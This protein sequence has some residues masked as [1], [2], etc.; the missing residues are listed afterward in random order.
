MAR[1]FASAVP[2]ICRAVGI[3]TLLTASFTPAF[4]AGEYCDGTISGQAL[5]PVTAGTAYDI[6]IYDNS[7]ENLELRDHFLKILREAGHQ[8]AEGGP[9]MIDV[10]S[11]FLFPRYRR[12]TRA[13]GRSTTGATNKQIAVN[14]Q[15]STIENLDFRQ[16]NSP[17][18]GNRRF[19][20]SIDVRFEVR[21]KDTKEFLWLGQLTCTPTT[22]NRDLI[23]QTVFEAVARAIGK[24]VN[25]QPL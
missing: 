5:K 17:A 15:R 13:V 21:N 1:V 4:A 22:D 8:T 10:S 9:L 20:E 18:H 16:R 23:A 11:E 6:D 12:D 25:S 2:A 24:T 19:E 3:V 7:E 14:K